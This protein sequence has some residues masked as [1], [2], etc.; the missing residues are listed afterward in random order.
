MCLE[1]R[2]SKNAYRESMTK[3]TTLPVL[4]NSIKLSGAIFT[5]KK[6][7]TPLSTNSNKP[8]EIKGNTPNKSTHIAFILYAIC[9]AFKGSLGDSST[10]V[11][12][13]AIKTSSEATTT[14]SLGMSFDF[15]AD[16]SND[17]SNYFEFCEF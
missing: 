5:T 11:S 9:N 4:K 2:Q 1:T 13:A 12:G 16:L 8:K 14:D 3:K 10:S 15:G 6:R 7:S 17:L